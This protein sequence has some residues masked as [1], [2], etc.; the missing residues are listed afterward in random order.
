MPLAVLTL[1]LALLA[2]AA[3]AE[4]Q[5]PPLTLRDAVDLAEQRSPLRASAAALAE[6]ADLAARYAGRLINPFVDVRFENIG[7]RTPLVPALDSFAVAS[8]P[9]ELAGKRGARR[10]LA[11]AESDTQSLL[12]QT[13]ERQIALD[14]MRAYMRAVRA[15]DV[16][17]TITLQRDGVLTLVQTMRRRFEEGVAPEADVMRFEAESARIA[18]EVTRTEIELTRSL[19]ELGAII[20]ATDALDAAQLVRPEPLPLPDVADAELAAAIERRPD[21]QLASARLT[22]TRLA[23]DLE[24]LRRIPDPILNG[25]YKRTMGVDTGVAGVT[26]SVPMFDHNM[27][28]RVRAD[29]SARAATFDLSTLRARAMAEARSSVAAARALAASAAR[30]RT[31]LL[32]P[33]EGVRNAARATFREG[34]A[35]VLR[36]VDAERVY[37]D[38]Q[39]EA[40]ALSVDAY[41]ASVEARFAIAEEDIP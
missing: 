33:A 26:F 40:L 3:P 17:T 34:A 13:V 19:L 1:L 31:D 24:R 28:A 29:A 20:G 10:R 5:V 16:L 6:G 25:G 36:L 18:A 22:Q 32:E 27:Q 9:I 23:A 39:R 35:D 2:L 38:V 11:G 7:P 14:T 37:A 41:I 4:A 15:R 21:L 8:Q 12:L 30:V